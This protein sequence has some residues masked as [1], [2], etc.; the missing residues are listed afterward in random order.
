MSSA[1]AEELA[2]V[3]V[4]M[5]KIQRILVFGNE[6]DQRLVRRLMNGDLTPEQKA[7]FFR[8]LDGTA[9]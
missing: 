3:F 2:H 4:R 5:S 9:Q 8:A 1:F 6:T 7:E